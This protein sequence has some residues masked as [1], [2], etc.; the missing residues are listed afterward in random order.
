MDSLTLTQIQRQVQRGMGLNRGL[1]YQQSEDY[2]Y[3]STW[4]KSG[5]F[6]PFL[7]LPFDGW[8][9]NSCILGG[10]IHEG[11]SRC[12]HMIPVVHSTTQNHGLPYT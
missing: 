2:A 3:N 6:I 7:P 11:V 12:Y 1:P 4:K 9:M 5:R 10:T 8:R